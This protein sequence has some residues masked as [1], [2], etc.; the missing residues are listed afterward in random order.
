MKLRY[1]SHASIS[2]FSEDFSLITDPWLY[3]PI[4]GG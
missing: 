3:E 2:I 1:N 4:Y